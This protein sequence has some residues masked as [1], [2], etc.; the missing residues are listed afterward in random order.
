MLVVRV[1]GTGMQ[2]GGA[3]ELRSVAVANAS[4]APHCGWCCGEAVKRVLG[5]SSP[6][7]KQHQL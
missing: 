3:V 1:G 7:Q 6:R 4:E 2:R 5:M